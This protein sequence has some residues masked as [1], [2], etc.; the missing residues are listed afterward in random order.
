MAEDQDAMRRAGLA[1]PETRGKT[2]FEHIAEFAVTMD[3]DA[4][5]ELPDV[6]GD[7][8]TRGVTEDFTSE[9]DSAWTSFCA[10]ARRPGCLRRAPARRARI[11]NGAG[12]E[13]IGVIEREQLRLYGGMSPSRSGLPCWPVHDDAIR[14]AK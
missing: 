10:N 8:L 11:G 2:G 5:A 9:G 14:L 13:A 4:A 7:K 3:F 1:R 6:G 12:E